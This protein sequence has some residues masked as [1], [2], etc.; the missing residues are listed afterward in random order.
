MLAF[1][2]RDKHDLYMN[3]RIHSIGQFK[4][5]Q[6]LQLSIRKNTKI[7]FSRISGRRNCQM[8]LPLEFVRAAT[9]PQ[10][11][12]KKTPSAWRKRL[13]G[14]LKFPADSCLCLK[15]KCLSQ[16]VSQVSELFHLL[17]RKWK[18]R[19]S[20]YLDYAFIF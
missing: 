7:F 15:G 4:P 20:N 19:K 13:A 8:A 18:I 10:A 11:E 6:S 9:F 3:L 12:P 14:S 2:T 17:G 5:E 1:E 16:M